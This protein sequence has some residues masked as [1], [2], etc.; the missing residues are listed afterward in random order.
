MR[1]TLVTGAEFEGIYANSPEPGIIR[2]NMVQQ[3]KLPNSADV[4]GSNPKPANMMSFRQ[5]EITE[6]RVVA[7]NMGKNDGKAPN[8]K[9]QVLSVMNG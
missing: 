4:N 7:N 8:G 1:I 5:K 2:L 9:S 6:A 3:K